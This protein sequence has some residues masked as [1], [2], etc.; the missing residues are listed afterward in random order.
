MSMSSLHKSPKKKYKKNIIELIWLYVSNSKSRYWF[1]LVCI[2]MC[3]RSSFHIFLI[4]WNGATE[5]KRGLWSKFLSGTKIKLLDSE[6]CSWDISK[7][8]I[9]IQIFYWSVFCCLSVCWSSRTSNKS[10]SIYVV[11]PT[12]WLK[13]W[14][15]LSIVSKLLSAT[16][17]FYISDA[18]GWYLKT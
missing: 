7:A 14:G 15:P 10:I 3:S 12:T 1:T 11:M 9:D 17:F 8:G 4:Q 18:I 2:C 5:K 6:N 13:W 16:C